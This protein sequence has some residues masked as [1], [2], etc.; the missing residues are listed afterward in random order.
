MPVLKFICPKCSHIYEELVRVGQTAP[1]PKCGETQVERYYQ[2]KCSFGM[3]GSSAG[4]TTTTTEDTQDWKPFNP[5]LS[6]GFSLTGVA[7]SIIIS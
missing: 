6:A 5:F 2:G 4:Y 1:C 7:C 3:L